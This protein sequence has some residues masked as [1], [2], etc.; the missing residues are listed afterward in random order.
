VLII[1]FDYSA[2][3]S[4]VF[5]EFK[6]ALTLFAPS[7]P[8][9]SYSHHSEMYAAMHDK[10]LRALTA[11]ELTTRILS[12]KEWLML[13]MSSLNSSGTFSTRPGIL[14]LTLPPSFYFFSF[15]SFCFCLAVDIRIVF[16]LVI[17]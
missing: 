5:G 7:L 14:V 8:V 4:Q 13:L 3:F 1:A 16:L 9:F 10:L 11:S 6:G 15:L 17:I 12:G 2:D